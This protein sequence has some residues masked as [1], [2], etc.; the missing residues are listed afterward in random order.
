[1]QMN[2]MLC[3]TFSLQMKEKADCGEKGKSSPGI[4]H[5]SGAEKIEKSIFYQLKFDCSL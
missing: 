3:T 1:M 5:A 2:W 4:N